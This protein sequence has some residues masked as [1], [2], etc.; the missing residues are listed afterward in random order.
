MAQR[1]GGVRQAQPRGA[2]THPGL[3]LD[4]AAERRERQP[5][6]PQSPDVPLLTDAVPVAAA[7]GDRPARDAS[8][9]MIRHAVAGSVAQPAKAW[10]DDE[11]RYLE[12]TAR[13]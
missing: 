5:A 13:V 2:G 7:R 12:G 10:M 9:E 3:V 4:D 11:A 6:Q 1:L 8:R